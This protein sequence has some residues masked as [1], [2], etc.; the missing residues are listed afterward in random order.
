MRE[1]TEMETTSRPL[2]I[3]NYWV[4]KDEAGRVG[5][6]ECLHCKA[7]G[8][9]ELTDFVREFTIHGTDRR[10]DKDINLEIVRFV[11]MEL[12]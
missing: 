4:V 1:G 12:R 9:P 3:G 2:H 8:N 11:R 7:Y 10:S 5:G 6:R